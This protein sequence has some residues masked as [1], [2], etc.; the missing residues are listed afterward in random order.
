MLIRNIAMVFDAYAKTPDK[1][2]KTFSKTI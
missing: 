1:G 2:K